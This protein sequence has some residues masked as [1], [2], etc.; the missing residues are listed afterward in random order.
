MMLLAIAI[1]EGLTI[2]KVDVASAFMRTPMS[3]DVT[4]QW[5]RLDKDVV[6]LL[7]EL[8]PDKYGPYALPDGT[9][10]VRMK[11]LS[12]GYV[13]AAHYWYKELSSTF[14][15]N[16]YTNRRRINAC[17]FAVKMAM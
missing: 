16:N 8:E 2:F 3:D 10:I 13:E 11:H 14:E 17:S 15:K 6:N 9:M 4:H 12:Y 7:L 1:Y 5:V